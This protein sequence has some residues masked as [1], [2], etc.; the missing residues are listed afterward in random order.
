V[1][2]RWPSPVAKPRGQPLAR[3][4]DEWARGETFPGASLHCRE[5]LC[6]GCFVPWTVLAGRAVTAKRAELEALMNGRG[7]RP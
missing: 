7:W 3:S 2:G 4:N 6:D 5:G 1:Y